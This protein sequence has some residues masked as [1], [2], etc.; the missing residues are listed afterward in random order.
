MCREVH[1]TGDDHVPTNWPHVNQQLPAAVRKHA[2]KQPIDQTMTNPSG[3]GESPR[4]E[5]D[6][7]KSSSR[8]I[9]FTT[10]LAPQQMEMWFGLDLRQ[11]FVLGWAGKNHCPILKPAQAV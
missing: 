2:Q 6:R 5:N 7:T 10:N 1:N 4:L 9:R 11:A 3:A 8:P